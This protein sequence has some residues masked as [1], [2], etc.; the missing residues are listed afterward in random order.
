MEAGAGTASCERA[1]ME[2][3]A[4]LEQGVGLS[5][6][7]NAV[8]GND[9]QIAPVV[10]LSPPSSGIRLAWCPLHATSSQLRSYA[11]V[12]SAAEHAR[13]A[14]FGNALL[15]ERFT[16]G[17]AALRSVLAHA[18]GVAPA[19]V[20]IVRGTRGRPRLAADTPLDFNVS[21][22]GATALIGVTDHGRIGVDV[23]RGDRS[24]NLTGIARKFLT[25]NERD[26]LAPLD[27]DAARRQ[28][29]RLWTCK[30][31]MSK[32]TGDALSAPFAAIDV[33]LRDGP[34]LRGGPGKYRPAGWVLH[35][36]EMP[37]DYIATIAMWHA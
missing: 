21:H 19:D 25:R 10:A 28:V 6:D 20:V 29:L 8:P 23:E 3:G 26:A 34:A 9:A 18:L 17:R 7:E 27:S 13:A 16:I 12:L 11:S 37:G 14:R 2:A 32:A 35:A 30:E 1:R 15:R 36:V 22:T 5:L 24:I 33:D 4:G 31:A